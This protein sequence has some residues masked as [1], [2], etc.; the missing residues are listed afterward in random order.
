M[1]CLQIILFIGFAEPVPRANILTNITAKHPVIGFLLQLLRKVGG[2]QFN[3][4]IGDALRRIQGFV[5]QN[6]SRGACINAF[7]T[8]ATVVLLIGKVWCQYKIR[9]QG[10]KEKK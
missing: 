4:K 6:G 9:D 7:G 10:C 3:G 2:F 8:G 5:G 1:H